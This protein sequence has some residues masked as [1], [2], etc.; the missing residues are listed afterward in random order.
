[1]IATRKVNEIKRVK[2]YLNLYID[3]CYS[4]NNALRAR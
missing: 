1:L 2:R 4:G 3:A